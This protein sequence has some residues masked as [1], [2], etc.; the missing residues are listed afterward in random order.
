MDKIIRYAATGNL[1]DLK[2]II[3]NN[4]IKNHIIEKAFIHASYGGHIEIIKFL[5]SLYPNLYS[6]IDDALC[7]A[8]FSNHRNII[9]YLIE[10]GAKPDCKDNLCFVFACQ[11]GYLD[12]CKYLLTLNIN[13]KN[14]IDLCRIVAT[15]FKRKEII[16]YLSLL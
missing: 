3:Q 5:W 1:N 7:G 13:I 8:C 10:L 12:L 16:N 11:G 14:Q 6:T 2:L 9:D 15:T 4:K